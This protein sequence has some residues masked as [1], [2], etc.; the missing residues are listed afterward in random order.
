MLVLLLTFRKVHLDG[1]AKRYT[2]QPDEYNNLRPS[3]HFNSLTHLPQTVV[4][5]ILTES[6]KEAYE[7]I[8]IKDLQTSLPT[9]GN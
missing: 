7:A 6:T 8:H 4:Q 2:S 3:C 1:Y 5:R 9:A